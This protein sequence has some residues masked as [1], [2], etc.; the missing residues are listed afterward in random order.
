MNIFYNPF[1]S[2]SR[3]RLE[4]AM[5]ASTPAE[6]LDVCFPREDPFEDARVPVLTRFSATR[7]EKSHV[8]PSLLPEEDEYFTFEI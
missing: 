4:S 3:T 5:M 6:Q 2:S 8:E 1:P 7:P